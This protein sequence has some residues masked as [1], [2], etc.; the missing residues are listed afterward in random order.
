MNNDRWYSPL[1]ERVTKTSDLPQNP[2]L[3]VI[4][5]IS[6]CLVFFIL[7]QLLTF[8]FAY[9]IGFGTHSVSL[10]AK[11][12]DNSLLLS[13]IIRVVSVT[14]AGI[15]LIYPFILE[16]PVFIPKRKKRLIDGIVVGVS[17]VAVALLLNSLAILSGFTQSSQSFE[18]TSYNQFSLPIP[19]G[20]LLYGIVT[21]IMEELVYRG[22]VYNRLHRFYGFVAAILGSSILFGLSHG[23]IVQLCYGFVMGLIICF[24]YERFGAFIYPLLFHCFA[25]VAVYVGM[26][27]TPLRTLAMSLAGIALEIALFA[28]CGVYLLTANNIDT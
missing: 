25:N 27:I 8:I 15:P 21:P 5:I 16:N 11:F 1:A 13:T 12:A 22:L 19:L 6:P 20:I 24:I 28:A 3:R 17:A 14:L 9:I 18:Q 23:N 4:S 26:S 10:S 7:N 2:I